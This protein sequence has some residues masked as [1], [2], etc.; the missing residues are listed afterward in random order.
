MLVRHSH[1]AGRD[2]RALFDMQPLP[3]DHRH[4]HPTAGERPNL[5]PGQREP[6]IEG[7]E[8]LPWN[9]MG[10]DASHPVIETRVCRRG[11]EPRGTWTRRAERQCG[12]RKFPI[13]LTGRTEA[14]GGEV[15][16]P[17]F[18]QTSGKL[19]EPIEPTH[20][21]DSHQLAA[22]PGWLELSQDARGLASDTAPGSP[23]STYA[24]AN[25]P[26]GFLPLVL[27]VS[28][29][30][31][32]CLGAAAFPV[33]N[34][35]HR[36]VGGVVLTLALFTAG[37][38]V[39]SYAGRVHSGGLLLCLAI[40]TLGA[41]SWARNAPSLFRGRLTLMMA[42]STLPL[43]CVALAGIVL[44]AVCAYLLPVWQWDSLGYHLPFVNFVLQ[45]GGLR[46][47][48]VD[49]PY[50]TTYPRNVELIYVAWRAMLPDDR[51]V[52]LAQIP[53]GLVG[54]VAVGAIARELGARPSDALVAGTLWLLIPAVY[55]QL[56]TNYIDV[57]TGA[58]FLLA[59]FFLLVRPTRPVLLCSGLAIG[60]FLGTK[61]SVPP[62][63]ALLSL[64]LLV[65]GYRA[66]DCRGAL[67]GIAL[68][69]AL[70][71]EAY[72]VNVVRHGNP[73]WPA[74][75]DVGP[76]HLPGTISVKTL[77]G[78]GADTPQVH[79]SLPRRVLSSWSNL[80]ALPVFDMRV[81]G[82]SLLFWVAIPG[83][84]YLIAKRRHLGLL[85]LLAAAVATPDPA[86][87]RY[88]LPVP[89]LA[90]A[91]GAAVLSLAPGELRV[92]AHLSL[93][94]LGAGNLVYAA[95][96]L[97]GKGP[98]LWRYLSM[99]WDERE[100]AVGADGPPVHFVQARNRL[101]PSELAIYDRSLWLPYLMWRSDLANHV[102]RV[103]DHATQEQ[104]DQIIR[105]KQVRLI[106]GGN[107]SAL[108]AAIAH[109][110]ARYELLFHCK[111][112]CAVYWQH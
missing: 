24:L 13:A 110:P 81:G 29:Y 56:P 77:L 36:L 71:L 19:S 40:V 26:W 104:V 80:S 7:D 42:R 95:H 62:A 63:A 88:V 22:E 59:A 75:V 30:V 9:G 51:L 105:E 98:P 60:L 21:N 6:N 10:A 106:A 74:I 34:L 41:R 45:S 101:A 99:S 12:A 82:M 92:A 58:Y 89:G 14:T 100:R 84:L 48:P 57:A 61:P 53:F 23:M 76:F 68:A 67:L 83:A 43:L 44:A 11:I 17:E 8:S 107:G 50:L 79:G 39:L 5:A 55:L 64:I 103:P 46:G 72:V 108:S 49:V 32:S 112:P 97:V 25:C 54:S 86:I 20:V 16:P 28:V 65:R 47:L 73:V 3:R 1:V 15:A 70:G 93:S 35:G 4:Q 27:V 78:S 52:D 96:G 111:E 109:E 85:S 31:A 18:A 90:L 66:G 33:S 38:Q 94:L 102:E 91:A 69:G 37:M 2:E 87:A